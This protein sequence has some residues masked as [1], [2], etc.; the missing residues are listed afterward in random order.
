MVISLGG[1]TL[2]DVKCGDDGCS[3]E[4]EENRACMP[5]EIPPSD[6]FSSVKCLMFVRTQEVPALDCKLG[7][8][9]RY[10]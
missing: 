8:D 3:T 4:G 5:I 7:K 10:S 9:H 2:S 1:G 6:V